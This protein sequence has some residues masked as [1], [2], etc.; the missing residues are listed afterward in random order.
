MTARVRTAALLGTLLAAGAAAPAQPAVTHGPASGDPLP[1]TISIWVRASGPALASV[2]YGTDP[3][4]A[5][6]AETPAVTVGS[7][8][9]YTARIDITGLAPWT[10]WHYRVRLRD[11]VNPQVFSLSNPG[12]FRTAPPPGAAQDLTVAFTA[13]LGALAGYT[14]F[15][16]MAAENPD[17][18]FLLGDWPYSDSS[19]AA[20]TLADYRQKHRDARAHP[21]LQALFDLSA[22]V[23]IWDDHEIQ[24]DWDAATDPALVQLGRAVWKEYMPVRPAGDTVFRRL[25]FGSAAEFFVLDDRTYRAVN[26]DPDLPGKT[27]LGA[28]QRAWLLAGLA[29]STAAFKFVVSS[30]PLRFGT[31]NKDH[32]QGFMHERRQILDFIA[33]Q[34]IPGVVFLSGDQHWSAVHHHREGV[35][36]FQ[37]CPLSAGLRPPPLQPEPQVV[38]IHPD[39]SYGILRIQAAGPTPQA[40]IEIRNAAGILGT[41]AFQAAAPASIRVDLDDP[42]ALFVLDGPHRFQNRGR[43]T[44]LPYAPPGTY[45]LA[46]GPPETNVVPPGTLALPVPPGGF[47]SASA[48]LGDTSDPAHPL[49][50]QD[51]FDAPGLAGWTVVDQGTVSPPSAWFVDDF[52]LV[53]SSNIYGGS[54]AAAVPDKPGTH[55]VAG[56]ATWT[57]VTFSFQV[58][59]HDDDG[60]GALFRLAADGSYYRFAMDRQRDYRRLVRYSGG[61][62]TT[63]AETAGGYDVDRWIPIT[64]KAIGPNLSVAMDGQVILTATDSTIPAG[65]IALYVWGSEVV[66]FD[67]VAVRAGDVPP[68]PPGVLLRQDFSGGSLAGWAAVDQGTISAPSAWSAQNGTALQSSNIYGGT[69]TGA[70][71]HKPG[72]FLLTGSPAWSDIAAS[73]RVMN[74]DNDAVGLMFRVV[75]ADNYYRFSMDSE[76]SY[77]RLTKTVAGTT[78]T[79]VESNAGYA[80]GAWYSI[81][82]QA[83]G[84]RLGVWLD[85][86]PILAATDATFAAGRIALYCW[87]STG[88]AYDDVV[89]APLDRATAVL[90]AHGSAAAIGLEVLAPAWP[91]RSYLLGIALSD[92]PGIPLSAFNPADPR[93]VPLALDPLL[94][95]SL[96]PQPFLPGFTGILDGAGRASASI[97]PP[98]QI[99]L[100][101]FSFFASGLVLDA[102]QPSGVASVLPRLAIVIP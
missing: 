68:G 50:F 75:D 49:L 41:Y 45:T 14:L 35:K 24:N 34:R 97:L 13:D 83:D 95:L 25:R 27:M 53:Q 37:A 28:A 100:P 54:T 64:I 16:P 99:L 93:I 6:P 12:R 77:R 92:A 67:D 61:G 65:R 102:A 81:L 90:A 19:P 38:A 52:Q 20:A 56:N 60:I 23:P 22:I 39:W 66:W 47:L 87:G 57:D 32:W 4:L 26:E 86:L 51:T 94:L 40:V 70:D 91:G 18:T 69:L 43:T 33:A 5:S 31:T 17:V 10:V 89:V 58:K 48:D 76:R 98:P 84:P 8:T 71:P 72:T 62:F 21:A 88:A 46:L 78:T 55:L 3:G 59:T 96:Q 80:P 36:E 29:G 79:L 11:P 101:G 63:I 15:T 85:G 73:V 82:V 7:T 2:V 74:P 1:D 9:D 30:V 44:L 42:E